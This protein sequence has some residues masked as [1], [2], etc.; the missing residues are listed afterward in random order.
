MYI[1]AP[2]ATTDVTLDGGIYLLDTSIDVRSIT[3]HANAILVFN[4]DDLT[5]RTRY[6][7]VNGALYLGSE[8]CKLTKNIEITLYGESR[9]RHL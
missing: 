6:I 4:D 5:V 3:I 8:N 9:F 7:L 1:Q 2:D